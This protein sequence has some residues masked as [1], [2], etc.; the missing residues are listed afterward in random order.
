VNLVAST[1]PFA[2]AKGEEAT[3]QKEGADEAKGGKEKS[4]DHQQIIEGKFH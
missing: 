4:A 1:P 3:R 2:L